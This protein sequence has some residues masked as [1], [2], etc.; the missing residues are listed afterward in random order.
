LPIAA[1]RGVIFD[2]HDRPLAINVPAYNITIVPA[3]LPDDPQ[4]ELEIFNRIYSFNRCAPNRCN[5]YCIQQQPA[6][7]RRVS[8][9]R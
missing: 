5:S 9:R 3:N 6:E 8:G 4:A 7:H 2:R 1:P